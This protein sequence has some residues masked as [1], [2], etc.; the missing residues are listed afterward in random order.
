MDTTQNLNLRKPAGG[1]YYNVADQ[2]YNMDILDGAVI[3]TDV[4]NIR[5]ITKAAFDALTTKNSS[6]IYLV[7][8][9]GTVQE[10]LGD[11]PIGGGGSGAAVLTGAP[12][13]IVN[14]ASIGDE[15]LYGTPILVEE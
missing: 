10:Y 15:P 7:T 14:R 13:L 11:T 9:S 4:R 5:K 12:I 3:G 6:T 8:D 2:N 1:D